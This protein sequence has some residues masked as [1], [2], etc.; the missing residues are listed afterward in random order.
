MRRMLVEQDQSAVGFQHHVE[1][2]HHADQTQGHVE[3][4]DG[5]AARRQVSQ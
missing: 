1:P 2:T 4:R 5:G 3:Q